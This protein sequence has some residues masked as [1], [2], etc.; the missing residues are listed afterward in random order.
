MGPNF[1]A[2]K[3]DKQKKKIITSLLGLGIGWVG[4]KTHLHGIKQ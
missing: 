4:R 3:A 2:K 1:L